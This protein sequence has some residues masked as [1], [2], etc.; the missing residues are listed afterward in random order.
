MP[1]VGFTPN[2]SI[3]FQLE[4]PFP[5]ANMCANT[6]NL[7]LSVEKYDEF[8]HK[9]ISAINDSIGFGQV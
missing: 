7:P 5:M 2:P 6:L 4:S 9:F 3:Q 1:P 8:K